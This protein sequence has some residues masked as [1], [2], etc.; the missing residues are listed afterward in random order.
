M[1]RPTRLD[2]EGG[3]HHVLNRGTERC[4]IFRGPVCYRHFIE[5]LAQL[6]KRFGVRIHG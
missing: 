1:A 3:W 5:L 6:P 4:V 2:L